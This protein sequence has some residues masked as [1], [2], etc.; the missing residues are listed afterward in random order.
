MVGD[1]GRVPDARDEGELVPVRATLMA[2]ARVR[3][4]ASPEPGRD[5]VPRAVPGPGRDDVPARELL[6]RRATTR[7]PPAPA[8]TQ[9]ETMWLDQPAQPPP[10]TRRCEW[11]P[12]AE[13]MPR[14]PMP[15][16]PLPREPMPREPMPREPMPREPG[17]REGRPPRPVPPDPTPAR[18]RSR[19]TY[20]V[21]FVA[22]S[23]LAATVSLASGHL[24]PFTHPSAPVPIVKVPVRSGDPRPGQDGVRPTPTGTASVGAA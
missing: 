5:P 12:P 1:A 2:R 23:A 8:R 16:E 6:A 20:V 15:R 9:D 22:G 18:S 24:G 11:A 3:A 17:P 4:A 13:P 14:E 10:R 19:W 7:R 21:A